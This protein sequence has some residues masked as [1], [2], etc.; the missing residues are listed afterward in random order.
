MASGLE[1]RRY[2]AAGGGSDGRRCAQIFLLTAAEL[3]YRGEPSAGSDT[4][5]DTPHQIEQDVAAA[6]ECAEVGN[7]VSE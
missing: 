7:M 6:L 2:Q 3:L 5:A 4:M 1:P